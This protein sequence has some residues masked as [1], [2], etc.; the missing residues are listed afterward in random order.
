MIDALRARSSP[1]TR[2][3]YFD[4]DDDLGILWPQIL[5]KVDIYVKNQVAVD[6]TFYLRSTLGKSN[7]THY[8][9]TH[10]GTS[11]EQNEVPRSIPVADKADLDKIFPGWNLGASNYIYKLFKHSRAEP[12]PQKDIDVCCRVHIPQSSWLAPLRLAAIGELE[13]LGDEYRVV[14]ATDRIPPAKFQDE[15]KRSRIC[16]SPFGHGEICF[17]DFEAVLRGCLLIKPDMGHL[18]SRPDIYVADETYVPVQWEFSDLAEK[19]RYYL[20]NDGERARI[21]DC[22]AQVLRSYYEN[23]AFIETFAQILDRVGL[24]TQGAS[25]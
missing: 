11:F 18:E 3:L 1:G 17:R 10:H 12:T 2:F 13:R 16:V 22:A 5:R 19:C 15:L 25:R 6:R 20:E 4:G 24:R 23:N 9:A 7:L 21:A 8:V 14:A